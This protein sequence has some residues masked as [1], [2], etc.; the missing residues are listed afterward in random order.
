VTDSRA[1]I[2][3]YRES[4]WRSTRFEA[5]R[6]LGKFSDGRS[7][8]FLVE[9][10]EN[11][12]DL[13]EQ[14][15]AL[16]S[17]SQHRNRSAAAFIKKFRANCP[18][19]L[20]AA[21]A[22]A[23]GQAQIYDLAPELLKD[24]IQAESKQDTLWLKNLVLSFGEL[25]EFHAVPK[26]HQLL[27]AKHAIDSDLMIAVF[28]SLGRL[29][30]NL[31]AMK[32]YA[33]RVSSEALLNQIYQSA[34]SQ[35]QIRSQF[36]LEDYLTK[37]F[38]SA[39]P[40]PALPL[41]LKAF[42]EEEVKVGLSLFP[43]EKYWE[44]YLFAYR[45]LSHALRLELVPTIF[46][47]APG[48]SAFLTTAGNAFAGLENPGFAKVCEKLC[49]DALNDL[50]LRLQFCDDFAE[51][52]D[53]MAQS[54]FFLKKEVD[55]G[56]QIR[57]LNLWH[58]DALSQSDTT[59]KKEFGVFATHTELKDEAYAR[60]IRAAAEQ[61]VE[62]PE[63][64]SAFAKSFVNPALRPSLLVYA[65]RFA[66]AKS[67]DVI[68]ALPKKEIEGLGVRILAVLESLAEKD[69]LANH[70]KFLVECLKIFESS[71]SADLL[72]GLLRVLRFSPL[73]E[74][75]KFTVESAK[76]SD[77]LVELNAVIA[78]KRYAQSREGSEVLAQ[79]LESKVQAVRG[80]ALDAL[81]AHS[82]LL[83]KRS[84]LQFLALNLSD[85][86][87]VDKVY[88]SFDP[89]NKGG[90]E[91]VQTL[92]KILKQNPDHPLWEKL[93]SLKERV[94]GST[95][96][97]GAGSPVE[98]SPEVTVLDAR[99]KVLIP[100]FDSLDATTKFALRAAEQPFVQTDAGRQSIDKAPTVLEYCKALDLILDKSLGQKH[101]FP[102]LDTALHDF[103]TLWHRVGFGE[104]YPQLD[105][106]MN[107]LGL[108]G[109]ISPELFPLHKSKMMCGTFFNGKILQDRFKI[110]DGL[111]AWA[112][113]FLV[114]T[115]KIPLATGAVGPLLKM[116]GATDE[117]SI[118]I[119]KKLMT[120]QDLR[121]PAA[122]R[123]TYTDL[124]IVENVR[125]EAV[126]LINI[127]LG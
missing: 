55:A 74:F 97:E 66:L 50:E 41:E 8:Q 123:Q 48:A 82:T 57:F 89:E 68:Q 86:E 58:E 121:N 19:T 18:D 91:F 100:K 114:F 24:L 102:K 43:V 95:T 77:P 26:L 30:R 4:E 70:R 98:L 23:V 125:A 71:K 27:N 107:L 54:A 85:E 34:V 42:E 21:V 38:E 52:V 39:N 33:A 6:N 64:S 2:R 79:K 62:V 12:Q 106:V 14:E 118:T 88:R 116:D 110:F 28:L 63:I 35:I 60:L 65:E 56:L 7:F 25:K 124:S 44:R 94:A 31:E 112:V 101:L 37:I 3:N 111:R 11:N 117:Q 83:A 40:H 78:L 29:E 5:I 103:Q 105:K 108:K 90:D 9:I 99:L 45:G 10:V 93:L 127:I 53:F 15:L 32:P 96:V 46:K 92:D 84:V 122:H 22:Y 67:L 61:G 104:D 126:A 113:I 59:V 20:R 109:K 17:L 81:C 51:D 47:A 75:E 119:A 115:R 1:L 69:R 73:P 87:I 36:K 76:H 13:A 72:V 120:L 16:L 49:G 80:R